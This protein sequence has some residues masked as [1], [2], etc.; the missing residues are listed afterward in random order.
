MQ[1]RLAMIEELI[2]GLNGFIRAARIRTSSGKTNRPIVK[3]FPLE[4]T[5]AGDHRVSTC[6]RTDTSPDDDLAD[7]YTPSVPLRSTYN[8]CSCE[9]S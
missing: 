8:K 6:D 5:A 7:D 4:I 3:L 1:W 9:S 2:K